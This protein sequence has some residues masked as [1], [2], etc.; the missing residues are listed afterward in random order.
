VIEMERAGLGRIDAEETSEFADDVVRGLSSRPKATPPK[1][2][3]DARGSALYELICEQPEYYPPR[4][5]TA[6]LER[7]GDEIAAAVGRDALVFEYGAGSARKTALLLAA[8]RRPAAYVPVDISREALLSAA[9]AMGAR[10]PRLPVRPVVADFTAPVKLPLDDVPCARRLA[11]FPGSTIGN[12]DPPEAVAL[13]RRMAHDAGPGGML[14]VGVDLPKEEGALVAAYDD[15]RGVTAAFDLNLLARMNREL[16]GDFQLSGFRH[17][18]VWDARLSRVEMHLESC[19]AQRV[20]VAGRAFR[21][22]R[23]ETLHTESAY[24]WEPRA[25]DAL[26]AI[27]GWRPEAAWTDDRAWFAVKL[28]RAA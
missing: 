6:L 7:H 16:A 18:A 9:E 19:E 17:R 4:I 8:L 5:E 12:F 21:F 20:S 25:F 28:Y 1:W 2:L 13:L 14:L 22:A 26:A 10:F 27:S 11:F 3:Y 15:A 24:K 23:G